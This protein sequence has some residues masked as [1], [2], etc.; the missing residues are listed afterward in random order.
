MKGIDSSI[1]LRYLLEDDPVWSKPATRFIDEQCS[2]DDPGYVNVVVLAEV[3]WSLRRHPQFNKTSIARL[4]T[5]LLEADNLVIENELAVEAALG[6]YLA[7]EAG[8][9]DCLIAQLNRSAGASATHSI[10]KA[11]MRAGVFFPVTK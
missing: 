8:F 6:D 10:D 1:L 7:G 9:A 11:A 5:E 3:V 2:I 4:V